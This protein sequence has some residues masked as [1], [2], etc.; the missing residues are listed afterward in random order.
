MRPLLLSALHR[1]IFSSL[2][3]RKVQSETELAMFVGENQA[4]CSG[5]AQL[6]LET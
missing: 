3:K 2:C 6:F 4:G 1:R 5:E